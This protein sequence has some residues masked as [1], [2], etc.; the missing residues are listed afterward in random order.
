MKVA[1]PRRA[2]VSLLTLTLLAAPARAATGE[3]GA[4][5]LDIPVGAR[6]A[7]LGGAYSAEAADGYAPVFNPAGLGALD[8]KR[9]ALTHL[10]HLEADYEFAGY[11]HPLAAG[12]GLGA[13]VQFYRPGKTAGFDAAGSPTGDFSGHYGAYTLAYGLSA[14]ERVSVGAAGKVVR[15]AIDGVAATAYAADLGALYRPTRRLSLA[16]V[17]ANLGGKLRFL[18][19]RDELP[20][21][22]R[23]GAAWRPADRWTLLLEGFYAQTGLAAGRA[24]VEWRPLEPMAL[25]VGFKNETARALEPLAGLSAGVGLLVGGHEFSYAWEPRGDLGFTQHFS[26]AL[27][28]GPG[29]GRAASAA[30]AAAPV[31]VQ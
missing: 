28:F 25:R 14:G 30:P 1:A 23:A 15:A 7:A 20:R 21:A 22:L 24:G 29:G 26:L 12:G 8:A 5:F 13:A 9:L 16:L 27:R 6:P 3:E 17:A 18:S 10:E 11:A 4:S 19:Q 31:Y 2:A